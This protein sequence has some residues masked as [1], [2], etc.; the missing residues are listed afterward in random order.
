MKKRMVLAVTL[1]LT[2]I[3]VANPAAQA[4]DKG[5]NDRYW[6][7]T[8]STSPLAGPIA[9]FPGAP[10]PPVIVQ[11]N[12]TI[13]QIVHVS[14]GGDAVQV[15]FS[16]EMG[17][18]PLEIGDARIAL[19][20]G[21]AQIVEGTSRQLKFG[22]NSSVTIPPGAP[23]VSDPLSFS[24][25][26][27]S[28]VAISIYLEQG[29]ETH[30]FHQYSLQTSYAWLGN[31]TTALDFPPDSASV[32]SYY[33]LTGLSVLAP[34][35]SAA[36][37][38]FGDSITDG[39]A[40]TPNANHQW[41]DFLAARLQG[42]HSMDHLAVL[43]EGISGNRVLNDSNFGANPLENQNALARLDRDVLRQPGAEYVIVF[44]GINDITW[45]WFPFGDEVSAD[46]IIGGYRQFIARAHE[47]GLKIYG[48]TITPQQVLQF[49]GIPTDEQRQSGEVT[50]QTINQWIRT[51][52]EYDGV[53]DFDE[54][55]RDPD[56]PD[57][58]LPE[59]DGGDHI[60]LSDA[61]YQALADAIDLRLFKN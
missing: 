1:A 31:H 37:V 29:T 42:L 22:G 6:V 10:E 61:G 34:K 35:R 45:S 9:S 39:Y 8:W 21:G 33:F 3:A 49:G 58:L 7:G 2:I 38:A 52:G 12:G 57:A 32:G 15:R 18:T 16:N 19:S 17:T 4:G 23:A 60:H 54:A 5:N 59:Y 56:H 11:D 28:N 47:L 13:R 48:A 20:A 46:D 43:N 55:V 30:T 27:L 14:L 36:I 25:P 44:L 24:L 26:P 51:S 40:S 53:I 41:P 50:R